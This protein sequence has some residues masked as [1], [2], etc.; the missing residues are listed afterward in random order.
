MG[1]LGRIIGSKRPHLGSPKVELG[2]SRNLALVFKMLLLFWEVDL[3][4][5]F[6]GKSE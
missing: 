1:F 2:L 6:T 4:I 5:H 3:S